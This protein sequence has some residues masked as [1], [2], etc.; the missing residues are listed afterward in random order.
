MGWRN[1]QRKWSRDKVSLKRPRFPLHWRSKLMSEKNLSDSFKTT[2]PPP[3][4]P[5][6]CGERERGRGV[7]KKHVCLPVLYEGDD[8]W[9]RLADD[10][11]A[12]H[13]H[14]TITWEP[15][16]H[17][18]T[19]STFTLYTGV[20]CNDNIKPW[21]L[22]W[23][24]NRFKLNQAQADSQRPFPNHILQTSRCHYWSACKKKKKTLTQ[25][26]HSDSLVAQKDSNTIMLPKGLTHCPKWL[27]CRKEW[28]FKCL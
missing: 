14:Y 27:T 7:I 4:P 9:V 17:E 19:S 21:E 15:T 24:Q 6:D 5:W 2:P 8:L 1:A 10:A 22:W 26:G 16:A 3:P 13:L 12:V 18:N 11:L 28:L 23:Y 20:M 25:S